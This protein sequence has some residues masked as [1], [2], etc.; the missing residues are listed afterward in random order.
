MLFIYKIEQS[1]FR[2]TYFQLYVLIAQLAGP[3]ASCIAEP[4]SSRFFPTYGRKEGRKD[5]I[6][7]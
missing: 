3:A 7:L 1:E 4:F 5:E 6:L 2:L